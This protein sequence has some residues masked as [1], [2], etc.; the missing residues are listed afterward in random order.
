LLSC[1]YSDPSKTNEILLQR[2]QHDILNALGCWPETIK[3]P[4]WYAGSGLINAFTLA[5]SKNPAHLLELYEL[6]PQTRRILCFTL[7][8]L[9]LEE[10]LRWSAP[11][12]E[13]EED[14]FDGESY[15]ER[16][17]GEWKKQ[18]VV[19]LDPFAMWRQ[20]ADQF[21]RDR[22][23]AVIQGLLGRGADAPSLI[24]F[25]TWGRAF[26]VADGDLNGTNHPVRNGYQELRAK[27]HNAGFRFVRV[28]WRWGLQFA[29][30]IVVAEEHLAAL[31]DEIGMHCRLLRDH[32]ILHGCG[33]DL[34]HPIGNV[35]I[36]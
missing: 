1:L 35:A 31:R 13:N 32:L 8:D 21:K 27:L 22:Y 29:M 9:Q 12:P 28:T 2:I 11:A 23:G 24:L 20:P 36:D 5:K 17:V 34:P 15:I 16:H 18:D 10:K 25:W 19:L 30:W 4:R 14:E 33:R 7:S 3:N 26:P 6:N